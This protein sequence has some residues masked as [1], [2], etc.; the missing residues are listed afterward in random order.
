VTRSDDPDEDTDRTRVLERYGFPEG[1]IETAAAK[2]G[3][4]A[5]E[6][7]ALLAT[8]PKCRDTADMLLRAKMREAAAA[9][10]AIE[11]L[12]SSG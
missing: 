3:A 10:R 11:R 4:V 2:A 6:F 1:L 8:F 7:E 5:E 9:F 12:L